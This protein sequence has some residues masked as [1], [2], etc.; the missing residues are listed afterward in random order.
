MP[1]SEVKKVDLTK[2]RPY[3]DMMDD[4]AVQMSFTLPLP[5][6]PETVEAARQM[7]KTLG[8]RDVN[9]THSEDLGGYSF[10]VVYGHTR[11]TIDVTQIHVAKAEA[12]KLSLYEADDA[13]RERFGRKLVVVG[14]CIGS[15]AHT[16][17]I[18]AIMN[19]KG[20]DGHYG[21]ERYSMI[22]AY[23]LGAQ[24]PPEKLLDF[25]IRHGADAILISQVITERGFHKQNLSRMVELIE[26]AGIR[27]RTVLICGGPRVDHK[28]ALELGYDAGF[29]RGTYPEQ[30]ASFII[31]KM[32]QRGLK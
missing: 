28:L 25:A 32:T 20:F 4:G 21:L 27:D 22:D 15:D 30:V 13:I 16:V 2:V 5:L 9:V 23:N 17:G 14:A 29:G 18:D 8:L 7:A 12:K 3:G 19:M 26:A 24:V 31:D 10:F 1:E 6:S 11:H